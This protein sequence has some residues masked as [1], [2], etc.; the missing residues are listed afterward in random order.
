MTSRRVKKADK[1]AN[2]RLCT[3]ETG[4]FSFINPHKTALYW[5]KMTAQFKLIVVNYTKM[6]KKNSFSHN[7][8]LSQYYAVISFLTSI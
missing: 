1:K 5:E 7:S 6:N 4:N 2:K 3:E 8:S